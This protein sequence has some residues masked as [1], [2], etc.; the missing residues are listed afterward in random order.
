MPYR[1]EGRMNSISPGSGEKL[2]GQQMRLS[3]ERDNWENR[4]GGK[5]RGINIDSAPS[6][7]RPFQ[8]RLRW[9]ADVGVK[10]HDRT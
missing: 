5:Y 8:D 10:G 6:E 3:V 1:N 9:F 4:R 2:N 7:P